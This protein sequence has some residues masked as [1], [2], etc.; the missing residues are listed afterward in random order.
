MKLQMC[1]YRPGVQQNADAQ[2]SAC[3][4]SACWTQVVQHAVLPPEF[5]KPP[6][7]AS[8]KADTDTGGWR[9]RP[10]TNRKAERYFVAPLL[11]V[12]AFEFEQ[13]SIGA[14]ARGITVLAA[15]EDDL[16]RVI[17]PIERHLML[18]AW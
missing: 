14:F 15:T 5:F 8:V 6:S 13:G 9:M 17:T 12:S 10:V 16:K 2:T 1:W 11:P 3:G 7:K 18:V 4:A